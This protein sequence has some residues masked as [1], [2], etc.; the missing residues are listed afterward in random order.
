MDTLE[1]ISAVEAEYRGRNGKPTLGRALRMLESRWNGGARD[2]E[3]TLR[4]MFLAWYRYAEPTDLT[5]LTEDESTRDLLLESFESL[6]GKDSK[7]PEFCFAAGVM[8]E[9]FGW[10]FGDDA[11]WT[12]I[13]IELKARARQLRPQGFEPEY[14]SGRGAYGDYFSHMVKHGVFAS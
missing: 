14:F 7:D 12:A 11:Q 2:H 5:G 1:Q 13:G 6:G 8:A 9:L 3:T 4:L 10:A